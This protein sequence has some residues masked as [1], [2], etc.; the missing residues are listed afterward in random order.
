MTCLFEML[1]LRRHDSSPSKIPQ[2]GAVLRA[3]TPCGNPEVVFHETGLVPHPM[4]GFENL[5][6]Y[7]RGRAPH[8]DPQ[9]Q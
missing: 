4:K 5:V 6:I 3:R 7:R 8:D 9:T 2:E 1:R